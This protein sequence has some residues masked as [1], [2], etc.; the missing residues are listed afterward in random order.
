MQTE[1][2]NTA[3]ALQGEA[4]KNLPQ[5]THARNPGMPLDLDWIASVQANT[6]AIER[7]AATLPGRRS[8]KK[9]YQAAWLCKA[10]SCIDLT[11]LSGDDTRGRVQRLC[12]KARQPVRADDAVERLIADY[13]AL[14]PA[15]AAKLS[16]RLADMPY[17][18]L[19]NLM[20]ARLSAT[21][22]GDAGAYPDADALLAD[23]RT[24]DG[25]LLA[26]RG[27]HAGHFALQR[28]LWRVKT[29]G[30]HLATL[31]LRQDSGT[32]DEA[33]AAL[34]GD[35]DWT[36]R[37]LAERVERLHAMIDGSVRVDREAAG[38]RNTLDVFRT[39]HEA[40]ATFGAH[41]FGPYIISMSRSAAD[42]LAV[43][44]LARTAG[45]VEHDDVPL[46][47]AP[48]FETIDDLRAAPDIMRA[49]FGDPVYRRHLAARGDR[50]IV[51]LGDPMA[52]AM[53]VPPEPPELAGLVQID[54][55]V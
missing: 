22:A 33:V 4:T 23:L 46:D 48:L 54:M 52:K 41:A 14:L 12:A 53:P 42:A 49:L 8:V 25:S 13:T 51:M 26:N 6:S 37:P 55:R 1:H 45:C 7:R 18:Q 44:A 19:I 5:I 30:F 20:R 24:I 9:D 15:D 47:V 28:V 38:A 29:F 36:T 40:R 39:V 32:H 21:L 17:R 27:E 11:T 43:L 35:G 50:Q 31:D 34:L 16:P 10:I 3:P 2:P